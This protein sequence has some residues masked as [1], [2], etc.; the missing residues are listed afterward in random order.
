MPNFNG[1]LMTRD[2]LLC[3]PGL[4]PM[5]GYE[6]DKH[7]LSFHCVSGTILNMRD[8]AANKYSVCPQGAY[9][10]LKGTGNKET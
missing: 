5:S 6:N 9:V 3:E 8:L 2:I 7:M 4:F 1:E 10:L